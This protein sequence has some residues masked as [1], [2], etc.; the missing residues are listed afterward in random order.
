[1]SIS[2]KLVGFLK[3]NK[4]SYEVITHPEA[5]TAQQVAH[6]IHQSGKVL[7]KTVVVLADGKHMMV[8][9]PAHHRVTIDA[10][11]STIGAKEVQIVQEEVLRKLFPDCDLGA[12]P[13]LGNMYGLEVI[14]SKALEGNVDIIFNAC[15]H[16]DCVKM[17]YA[18]FV[19]VVAP[20]VAEV[21]QIPPETR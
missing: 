6:A 1:M 10:V 18:D 19:R 5:F 11:K 15:T 7:A 2:E 8:V 9:V 4:I 17:H 14:V 16:T 20:I 12:M 21:S 3:E 13:P